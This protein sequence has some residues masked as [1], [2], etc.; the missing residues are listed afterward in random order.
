MSENEVLSDPEE[1]ADELLHDAFQHARVRQPG[2]VQE[3]EYFL[4][5]GN[6]WRTARK[7]GPP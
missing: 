3:D 7:Y 6:L 5:G 4:C 1:R 2:E